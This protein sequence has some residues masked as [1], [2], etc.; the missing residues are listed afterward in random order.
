MAFD[1]T[2]CGYTFPFDIAAFAYLT[3]EEASRV[4]TAFQRYLP[5]PNG[6][7]YNSEY[8]D[9]KHSLEQRLE[10]AA[11]R[12][13]PRTRTLLGAKNDDAWQFRYLG[14]IPWF[15]NL[16]D[17][18]HKKKWADLARVI[19]TAERGSKADILMPALRAYEQQMHEFEVVA[20]Y[21]LGLK[22]KAKSGRRPKPDAKPRKE[23]YVP[24]K[25]SHPAVRT[26]ELALEKATLD[27]SVE[28]VDGV[29][30]YKRSLVDEYFSARKDEFQSPYDL[31]DHWMLRGIASAVGQYVTRNNPDRSYT[32]IEK[33]NERTH[34]DA[35]DEVKNARVAFMG[36]I[37]GKVGP[38]L[39]LKDNLREMKT[40]KVEGK[41]PMFTAR[42][43]FVFDDNSTFVLEN[44]FIWNRRDHKEYLQF[45]TR[46][47]KAILPNGE[48]M[49]D[50][51]FERMNTVFAIAK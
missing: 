13:Y 5:E 32:K 20:L 16:V 11:R 19:K 43:E 8:G 49:A 14:E 31:Y 38:I 51:S 30:A 15:Y 3:D 26:L 29:V 39:T 9:L 40:F 34:A 42:L 24:G 28:M 27:V 44:K 1:F 48:A 18:T 47:T 33:Y 37:I 7:I 45:P 21:I 6:D 22:S 10:S 23:P 25:A 2:N 36:R 41:F 46:F 17:Y 4:V 12:L 35:R 50:L